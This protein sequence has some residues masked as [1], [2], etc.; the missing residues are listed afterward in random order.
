MACGADSLA[1]ILMRGAMADTKTPLL[2]SAKKQDGT[3]LDLSFCKEVT[4]VETL[5]L[6]GPRLILTFDDTFSILR[7]VMGI[8]V[9]DVLT[10]FLADQMHENAL[11]FTASFQI[12]SMPVDGNLVTL[13]CLQKEIADMKIPSVKARL[14][15]KET[16]SV[17]GIIKALAPGFIAYEVIEE[18]ALLNSYHLLPG[19]RPSLLLRQ[20]AIEHGAV[21]YAFRGKLCF[22]KL[23]VLYASASA[24]NIVFQYK[25]PQADFQIVD[26][27]H[28]N[29]EQ[30]IADRIVRRY[31]GFSITDGVLSSG[32]YGDQAP[33]VTAAESQAVLD[34]L[35]KIAVP[36]L[37]ITTWGAGHL[38]PGLPMRFQWNMDVS[39]QDSMEDASLP[40][41]AIVGTVAHYSAGAENYFCRVKAVVPG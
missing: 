6:S 17:L 8:K 7:N 1:Q 28:I 27:K 34:N 40:T 9:G 30:L 35:S 39:Y 15:T 10:C 21:I 37:D 26:Y 20:M 41:S 16:S 31:S 36:V 4:F 38:G 24:T 11:S 29:R 13:N 3:E 23:S 32:T 5:D 18:F 33:E 2:Q 25:N 12:M 14:F 19:E 22:R